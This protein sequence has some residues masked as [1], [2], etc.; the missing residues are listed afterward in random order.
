MNNDVNT[1]YT[2]TTHWQAVRR[3]PPQAGF[4][5]TNFTAPTAALLQSDLAG[6]A[7]QSSFMTAAPSTH[8][9]VVG[10]ARRHS[11]LGQRL[12]DL[13]AGQHD[14]EPSAGGWP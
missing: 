14:P 11:V 8:G 10:G 13:D 1:F 4:G 5:T 12:P 2:D 7:W 6:A 3:P 9:D